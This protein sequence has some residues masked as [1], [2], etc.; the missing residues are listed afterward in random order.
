MNKELLKKLCETAAISGREDKLIRFVADF[1]KQYTKKVHIDKLG[2]VSATFDGTDAEAPS[3]AFFAH[4]DEI[5]LIVRK[6]EENGFLRVE[7]IG[8]VPERAL[9][10]LEVQIHTL[11]GQES[12]PGV[13]GI[14]S[15]HITPADKKYAVTTTNDLYIDIGANSK[16]EVLDMGIDVGSVVTY[17]NNFRILKDKVLSK[18]LDDRM[19]VYNMLELADYLGEHPQKSTIHLIFSVQEEFNIRSCMPA[20][21]R[22]MPDAAICIDIT[23]ACDTPDTNGKY[24]VKLNHGPAVMY[25]NFHGRGTLGGLLPNP[26][27]NRFI[28]STAEKYGIP[29]QKEVI[30]GVIT[31][32]AFTQHVGKEG[33]PMAHLSIPLRYTHSPAETASVS[34]IDATTNLIIKI[35]EE[36]SQN[37][38]IGRGI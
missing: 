38:E 14:I 33:I 17:K 2:N 8:G 5:G 22:L 16:Q 9:V 24:D 11:D 10:S 3:I 37:I 32:D 27:L 36:F 28:E 29:V 25:M 19:G 15:H 30:I 35:S 4:L 21:S 18:A 6:V 7:R 12:Y 1:A 31:D 34:D 26:K 20:F 23:P 13:F